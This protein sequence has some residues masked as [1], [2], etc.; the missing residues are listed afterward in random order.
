MVSHTFIG[1]LKGSLLAK[2]AVATLLIALVLGGATSLW[3]LASEWRMERAAIYREMT[4]AMELVRA[5]AAEAAFQLSSDIANEVVLGLAH[6]S[7][8]A[9]I[10][11]ID[12]FGNQLS[13]YSRPPSPFSV[14]LLSNWLMGDV[15]QYEQMLDSKGLDG[16]VNKVGLLLLLLLQLKVSRI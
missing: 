8:V 3:E 15:T 11:L 16:Q 9:E 7:S 10:R 1:R 6:N 14:P 4:E 12:N 2:Q 5:T 13:H